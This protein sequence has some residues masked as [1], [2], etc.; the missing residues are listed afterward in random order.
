M[1][2]LLSKNKLSVLNNDYICVS[3]L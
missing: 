2:K 3:A 1:K